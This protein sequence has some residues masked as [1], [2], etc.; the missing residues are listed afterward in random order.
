M[1]QAEDRVYR[2]GQKN[3]VN[4]WYLLANDT[5]DVEIATLIDMKKDSTKAAIEG[6]DV[7]S[8]DK[9]L[10]RMIEFFSPAL[11]SVRKKA[12]KK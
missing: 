9:I 2:I 3:A 11:G 12:E 5:I 6:V 8:D 4:V 10:D 7:K 1:Q